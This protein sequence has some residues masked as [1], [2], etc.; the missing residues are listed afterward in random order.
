M[1]ADGHIKTYEDRKIELGFSWMLYL[2]I[3]QPDT[4]HLEI[5]DSAGEL[6]KISIQALDRKT[7]VSNYAK[8]YP[9]SIDDSD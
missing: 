8:N 5:K 3:S 4:F 7:Q 2:Y 1:P 6:K 9:E